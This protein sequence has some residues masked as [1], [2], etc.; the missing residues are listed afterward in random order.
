MPLTMETLCE[1]VVNYDVVCMCGGI[2]GREKMEGEANGEDGE[3][4]DEEDRGLPSFSISK[5]KHRR[6]GSSDRG[7]RAGNN[8]SKKPVQPLAGPSSGGT[9][10]GIKQQQQQQPAANLLDLDDIFGGGDGGG[11]GVG[12]SHE[13]GGGGATAGTSVADPASIGGGAG[14]G[15]G[16]GS[17][18][19]DLMA[20]IFSSP[21][22]PVP[23]RYF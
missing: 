22:G 5:A 14:A 12:A 4:D 8:A 16:P 11:V 18:T 1:L 17:P 2:G 23:V 15:A 19:V 6:G 13:G 3:E 7:G 21:P 10:S 9:G 20:E